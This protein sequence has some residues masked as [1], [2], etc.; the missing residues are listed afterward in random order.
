MTSTYSE[1]SLST[2]TDGGVR[3]NTVQTLITRNLNGI[4]LAILV[5]GQVVAVA[6]Q[7]RTPSGLSRIRY[8]SST[9]LQPIEAMAQT[10]VR[11]MSASWNRYVWLVDVREENQ[12]LGSEASRL[13]IENH[14]LRQKLRRFESR[15]DVDAYSET[16]ASRTLAASVVF[17]GPSR[18]TQELVLDRGSR[19]SVQTGLAVITP[20]GIVGKV[21]AVNDRFSMVLLI[22]D[23]EAGVGVVLAGSGEAGVLRGTNYAECR[24]DYIGPQ[25]NVE[26][27]EAIY[28]SGLDGVFPGGLPV[29]RVTSVGAGVEMQAISVSPFAPLDSL[30]DVLVVIEGEHE[31]LPEEILSR[32]RR[33]D[34]FDPASLSGVGRV[35][36]GTDADRIKQAYRRAVESQG[37]KVGLL[38]GTGPPDFSDAADPLRAS[39]ARGRDSP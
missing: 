29:G 8:W 6:S 5:V 24:L 20:A 19:H 28:T 26:V 9:L 34:Q 15:T 25:V 14:F 31:P 30:R 38:S 33:T 12:Q 32:M 22:S 18:S 23:S 10:T 39:D 37:R 36:A 16:I 4:L 7:V 35:V 17:R 2:S 11:T 27:G 3:R 21:Q 13:R 1:G